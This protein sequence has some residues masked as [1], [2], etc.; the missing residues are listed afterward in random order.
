MSAVVIDS[1]RVGAPVTP[2]ASKV[3]PGTLPWSA[4]HLGPARVTLDTLDT[5]GARGQV[6]LERALARRSVLGPATVC[7]TP[8]AAPRG[9]PGVLTRLSEALTDGAGRAIGYLELLGLHYP[10]KPYEAKV[11]VRD[12]SGRQV[13]TGLERGSRRSPDGLRALAAAKPPFRGILSLCRE[14]D[15]DRAM[16]TAL[17]IKPLRVPVLDND[18]PTLAQVKQALDFVTNP[19]NQPVFVHCEAGVGRTGTMIA[20]YRMA[21]CGWS[22]KEALAEAASFGTLMPNQRHF[23]EGFA[24]ELAAGRVPGYPTCA[25]IAAR[26]S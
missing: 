11:Y 19:A 14:N 2:D 21:V 10:V 20:C 4:L 16:A 18:H 1:V 6:S 3:E 12:A 8:V 25:P 26:R 22:A 13:W 24:A 23:V 9:R 17:G 5:L 15:D 7:P